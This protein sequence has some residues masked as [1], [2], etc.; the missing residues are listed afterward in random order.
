[1]SPQRPI[2]SNINCP[3]GHFRVVG[4]DIDDAALY[5]IGDFDQ[6]APAKAA[7]KSRAGAAHPVYVYAEDGTMVVRASRARASDPWT[8]A[9]SRRNRAR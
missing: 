6:L 5:M 8:P 2:L 3:P 4:V 7:A 9:P 1:M